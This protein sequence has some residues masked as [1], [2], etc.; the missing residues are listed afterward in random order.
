MRACLPMIALLLLAGCSD[1]SPP[2][3]ESGASAEA[4]QA[5]S[6]RCQP[7]RGWSEGLAGLEPAA[8][9]G[10]A[11]R[12]SYLQA[13]RLGDE[14]R[15][16]EQQIAEL[17]RRLEASSDL[18]EQGRLRRAIRQRQVDIEAIRG[19]AIIEGWQSDARPA[20]D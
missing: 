3:P 11:A 5:L 9:C 2:A 8:A 12:G 7:A 14:L 18:E 13:W 15:R 1:P 4:A 20:E 19:A 6:E 17:E 16:F 10:E